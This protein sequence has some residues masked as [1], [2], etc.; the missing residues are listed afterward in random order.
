MEMYR[1]PRREVPVRILVDDGRTLDGTLFT[2]EGSAGGQPEDVMHLLNATDE[3]FIPLVSGKDSFLLNKAGI[4]WVQVTGEP[5]R[6][7]ARESATGNA[8][9]VRMS[10]AGGIS[11]VGTMI[12]VMP[13]ERSRV[14]DYLNASGRFLPLFGD[15]A[16][17][18]VQ[19][20]FV[21]TV[22]SGER[23]GSAR[24]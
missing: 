2:A 23:D 18:L 9:P 8:V 1:V 5:A 3:D 10:L 24:G 14:K 7:L 12:I 13:Q 22:R 19:R 16:V 21:V 17:T 11:V 4:I 6:E 20:R 15:G